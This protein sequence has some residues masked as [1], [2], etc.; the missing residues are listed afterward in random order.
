MYRMG[1]A[2]ERWKCGQSCLY[3]VTI[4]HNEK[5]DAT[6]VGALMADVHWHKVKTEGGSWGVGKME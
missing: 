3:D 6:Y 5:R 1:A 2:D 4:L